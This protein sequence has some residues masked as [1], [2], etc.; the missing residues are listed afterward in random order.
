MTR[1][2]VAGT[3]VAAVAI[4]LLAVVQQAA[5]Q[6]IDT[7]TSTMERAA[8]Y[9]RGPEP[10]VD[11]ARPLLETI[12][13]VE[14]GSGGTI[15]PDLTLI[16]DDLQASPPRVDRALVRIE[17]LI[18]A[19]QHATRSPEQDDNARVAL[20]RVLE[21]E[22]FAIVE[23]DDG[24]PTLRERITTWIGDR[25]AAIVE[26]LAEWLAPVAGAGEGVGAG[27]VVMRAILAVIGIVAVVVVI[28][29]VI[30]NVRASM[31]SDVAR[32]D[33]EQELRLTSADA[34][35]DAERH[36]QSGNFR[37]ALR[38]MY[39]ATLLRLDEAGRLRFDRSLT[40]QEVLGVTRLHGDVTLQQRLVPLVERF[41]RVWYGNAPCSGDDYRT[42]SRLADEVWELP[43]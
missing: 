38:A 27:Y 34:R 30:R 13:P 33:A 6:D 4:M 10:D 14:V 24:P 31:T 42:F 37:E 1:R 35:A 16:L 43:A 26:R 18:D 21:R 11:A 7:Y 23:P 20:D 25:I 15:A 5:A 19:L 12:K 2:S 32:L 41:D 22:E 9:L 39:L 8:E 29:L 17:S 3:V 36:V 40:N 28:V